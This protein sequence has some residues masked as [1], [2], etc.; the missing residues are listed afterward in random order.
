M[1]DFQ[2]IDQQI[3]RGMT[4]Q[5]KLRAARLKNGDS[6][7]GWK[8]GFG[9]PA[10]MERLGIRAPLLGFLSKS[11]LIP[12][13]QTVA[14]QD[15]KQAVA[16]P[17]IAVHMGTDLESD[18]DEAAV[19]ASIAGLS[20]AIELADLS[21]PPNDVERILAGNVYQHSV[22]LGPMDAGRAG[23]RLNGLSARLVKDDAEIGKTTDMEANTGVII[24]LVRLVADC[25]AGFGL[26]LRA[27]EVIITGSVIPPVMVEQ[28]CTIVFNL[29]PFASIG[30]SFK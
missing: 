9:A 30:V 28:P 2:Q 3:L 22:I 25:L 29:E 10:V 8:I 15:F 19:R 7:L 13:G 20:S 5:L 26:T 21:F 17:E 6:S 11:A 4:T 24:D 23:A 18:A 12:S 27:G 14:L 16:E 1:A